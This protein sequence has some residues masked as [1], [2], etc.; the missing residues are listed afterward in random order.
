MNL[1]VDMLVVV[2]RFC[3]LPQQPRGCI[4]LCCCPR[5]CRPTL[6]VQA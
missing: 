4:V 5:I 2:V 3:T 6:F 1:S